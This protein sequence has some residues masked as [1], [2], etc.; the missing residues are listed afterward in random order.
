[1]IGKIDEVTGKEPRYPLMALQRALAASNDPDDANFIH[2]RSVDTS[3]MSPQEKEAH[4]KWSKMSSTFE[5]SLLFMRKHQHCS[6]TINEA[7]GSR[8]C[9]Q[10]LQE[11]CEGKATSSYKE[12][13]EYVVEKLGFCHPDGG[14]AMDHNVVSMAWEIGVLW[15]SV[16]VGVVSC[17]DTLYTHFILNQRRSPDNIGDQNAFI[18]ALLQIIDR[19]P[20]YEEVE[21]LQSLL[22]VSNNEGSK[23]VVDDVGKELYEDIEEDLRLSYGKVLSLSVLDRSEVSS[24][25][26][27]LMDES[28]ANG[29]L[30]P[31]LD[32]SLFSMLLTKRKGFNSGTPFHR[33]NELKG[34]LVR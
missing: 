21:S 24:L 16:A 32:G 23:K 29:G 2:G 28:V 30:G 14:L 18:A 3:K 22:K 31:S 33:R 10:T 25:A 1:M 7:T 34:R 13:T 17:I 4:A 9:G 12:K 19:C 15:P 8:L 20:A 27:P 11:F 6:P 26:L 5:T